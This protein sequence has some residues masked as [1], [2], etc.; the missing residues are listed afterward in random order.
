MNPND[1]PTYL[2]WNS[3]AAEQRL[4]RP[5]GLLRGGQLREALRYKIVLKA[6]Y[7]A[8][9]IFMRTSEDAIRR[10]VGRAERRR[11]LDWSFLQQ[12][13]DEQLEAAAYTRL[14]RTSKM[15]ACEAQAVI[16]QHWENIMKRKE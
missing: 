9:S 12:L 6:G 15:S 11:L 7:G 5:D 10:S 16:K 4:L 3:V 14:P 8:T 1:I 13:S 2:R